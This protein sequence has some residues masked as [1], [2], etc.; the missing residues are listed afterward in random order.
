MRAGLVEY[1]DRLCLSSDS[2]AH[3]FL[4]MSDVII[5]MEEKKVRCEVWKRK[6]KM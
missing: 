3:S 2:Y 5:E 1:I 6:G 4:S